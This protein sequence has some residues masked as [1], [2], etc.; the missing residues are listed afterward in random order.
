MK[1]LFVGDIFGQAGREI[2]T[3]ELPRLIRE[4][5]AD[6]VIANGENAA[7]GFGITPQI[8][9]QLL[10]LGVDV[11]TTGNHIWDKR[12][13]MDHFAKQPR[14]L[15]PGNYPE[16]N[17][18]SGLI[19]TKTK[20]G[21]PCAVMNLQGRSLM[22]PIDCPFRKADEYLAQ[23]PTETKIRFID[24]H[25]EA[26]SEKVA[27]GW[28]VNGRVTALIGTHT[29]IP[30]ADTRILSGGTAYQT[31]AGMTGPY[32]SVIGVE[33][34]MIVKKF[35]NALP[36]RMEP[37]KHGVELRGVLIHADAATGKALS[38]ERV[39]VE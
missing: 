26:T 34:E 6:L 11:I 15:R 19:Q 5:Q 4:R 9:T 3:R 35:L 33:K 2:V 36:I 17:P 25:A 39:L 13:I 1:I 21:I 8:C 27:L 31:D 30:T 24:F 23:I 16:G 38:A 14:L 20:S 7:G 18:G 29:H 32:D 12:E 28:Y 10:E 22:Q 37:A